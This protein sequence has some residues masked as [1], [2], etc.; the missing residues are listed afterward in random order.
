LTP[1]PILYDADCGFCRTSLAI[2]LAWDRRRRLR[3]VA[4]QSPEAKSLLAGMPEEQRMASWHLVAEGGEVNSAGAA[5]P[6][7]FRL[8][9]GGR[10]LAA[11]AARF[12]G[13]AQRAYT[14]VADRRSPLGR[15]IPAR[16]K[17]RADRLIER[18]ADRPPSR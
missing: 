1:L 17:R 13:A 3:P 6:Q 4:L 15:L 7:L 12:P 10:P 8:L 14:A 18:R 16:I 2:V 5:F 11:L 9:P